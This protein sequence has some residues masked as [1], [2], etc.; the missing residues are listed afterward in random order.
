MMEARDGSTY[1]GRDHHPKAFTMLLAGG[2]MKPGLTYGTTDDFGYFVTE[3][4]MTV[5]DLQA[6]ILHV[7]GLDAHKLTYPYLGLN[8]RLIGPEGKA[9]V[10]YEVL[11]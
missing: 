5:R 6:T 7:L 3:N 1:L 9:R 8:Q 4:E 2:G 11:A 10:H